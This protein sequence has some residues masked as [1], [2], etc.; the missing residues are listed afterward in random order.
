MITRTLS[1]IETFG[2]YVEEFLI[3]QDGTFKRKGGKIE[4]PEDEELGLAVER[5]EQQ[6]NIVWVD[7]SPIYSSAEVKML[8]STFKKENNNGI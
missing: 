3:Y 7:K 8:A 6:G 1:R 4:L 5:L 2:R